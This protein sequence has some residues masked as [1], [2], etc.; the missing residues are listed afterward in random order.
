MSSIKRVIILATIQAFAG[1]IVRGVDCHSGVPGS[2]LGG[3]ESSAADA[4]GNGVHTRDDL[5][6]VGMSVLHRHMI[7]PK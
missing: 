4:L 7:E 5:C 1:S 2:R 3:P 6:G